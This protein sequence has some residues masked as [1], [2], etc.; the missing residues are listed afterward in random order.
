MHLTLSLFL[1]LKTQFET[2][3]VFTVCFSKV[4]PFNALAFDLP[5][6]RSYEF[7]Q[8]APR[9]KQIGPATLA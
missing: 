5:K 1:L 8:N 9:Y 4:M 3:T 7:T 6:E 2:Q